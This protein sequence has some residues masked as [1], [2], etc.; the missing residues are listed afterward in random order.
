MNRERF[1]ELR[2][3]FADIPPHE[4]VDAVAEEAIAGAESLLVE[5]ERLRAEVSWLSWEVCLQCGVSNEHLRE[6]MSAPNHKPVVNANMGQSFR[7]QLA[8]QAEVEALRARAVPAVVWPEDQRLPAKIGRFELFVTR[9]NDANCWDW[10]VYPGEDIEEMEGG[11]AGS[12][13]DARRD[14]EAAFLRLVGVRE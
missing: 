6:C 13:E 7:E 1:E 8:L 5:V 10:Y 4:S 3:K 12:L 9:V 11:D 2:R 14:C